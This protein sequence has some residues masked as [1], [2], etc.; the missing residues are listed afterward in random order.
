[1]ELKLNGVTI[2]KREPR[3]LSLSSKVSKEQFDF[4]YKTKESFLKSSA[5]LRNEAIEKTH[6][7][8]NVFEIK[9]CIV[10]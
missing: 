8:Q 4:Q 3:F 5:V 10:D 6:F 9:L 1:M 2:T 7:Q